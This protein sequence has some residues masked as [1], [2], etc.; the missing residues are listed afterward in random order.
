MSK[1]LQRNWEK[2]NSPKGGEFW[3]FGYGAD[4]IGDITSFQGQAG[5]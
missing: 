1:I 3:L 4:G 5:S 2:K